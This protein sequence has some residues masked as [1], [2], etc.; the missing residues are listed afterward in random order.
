LSQEKF[1]DTKK[2]TFVIRSRKYKN[3]QFRGEKK[4][5]KQRYAK[6]YT[7]N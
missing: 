4:T 5:D 7:E 1:D 2:R 3:R 6:H